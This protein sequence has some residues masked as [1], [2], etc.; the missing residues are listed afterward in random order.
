MLEPALVFELDFDRGLSSPPMNCILSKV[1][2]TTVFLVGKYLITE[3]IEEGA[4][5][6]FFL[7][8]NFSSE[9]L[10]GSG[11]ILLPYL[12]CFLLSTPIGLTK[13]ST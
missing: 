4:K 5:F 11:I 6:T 13:D 12:G 10:P 7:Y 1:G 3:L 8:D 2:V 9:F